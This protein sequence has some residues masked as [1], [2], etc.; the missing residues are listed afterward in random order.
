M[1]DI[2]F[3]VPLAQNLGITTDILFG[4]EEIFYDK[5]AL[6]KIKANIAK[7]K[8]MDSSGEGIVK[9]CEYI[10][11]EIENDP[12]CYELF[13]MYVAEAAWISA[14]VNFEGFL[15]NEPEKWDKIKNE[16][17]RKAM[18]AIKHAK[19]RR[20]VDKAHFT[21]AWIYIHSKEYDNARKHIEALPSV[22][23]NMIQER[24]LDKLVLFEGGPEQNFENLRAIMESSMDKYMEAIA[25]KLVYDMET[26]GF[27]ADKEFAE[28]YG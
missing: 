14:K 8:E 5:E 4:M 15:K 1:P 19:D 18:I 23:T 13:V 12:T 25:A 6:D 16:A 11:E 27:K 10:K 26:Y 20:L 28:G 21:V 22:R 7:M 9:V 2:S 17:I 3:I 24:I